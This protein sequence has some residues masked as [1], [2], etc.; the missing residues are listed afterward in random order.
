MPGKKPP[1]KSAFDIPA[2]EHPVYS[3]KNARREKPTRFSDA[4]ANLIATPQPDLDSPFAVPAPHPLAPE[5]LGP[6]GTAGINRARNISD[7]PRTWEKKNQYGKAFSFRGL[8]PDL[9]RWVVNVAKKHNRRV[10]DIAAM[11]CRH[12]FD[13]VANGQLPIKTRPTPNG[14]T[15]F[16]NGD[17]NGF[18]PEASV[19]K[20]G[21]NKPKGKAKEE[22]WKFKTTTWSRFDQVLKNRIVEFCGENYKRGEFVSLLLLRARD[23]YE[24]GQ[25]VFPPVIE[26]ELE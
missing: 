17:Y 9:D 25:F 19:S 18:V 7:R 26:T 12:S 21:M 22:D 5:T 10:G 11:A 15:L 1:L 20:K 23:D 6:K 3:P 16:Q 14:L 24:S 4:F 8:R 2:T 13:L